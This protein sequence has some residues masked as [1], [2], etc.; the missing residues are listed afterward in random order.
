MKSVSEL[1]STLTPDNLVETL[2]RMDEA[3]GDNAA[4][5]EQLKAVCRSFITTTLGTLPAKSIDEDLLCETYKYLDLSK[6]TDFQRRRLREIARRRVF[7]QHATPPLRSCKSAHQLCVW[8]AV[9]CVFEERSLFERTV[10]FCTYLEAAAL[11]TEKVTSGRQSAPKALALA[12]Q[13]L[14]RRF[15]EACHIVQHAQAA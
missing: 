14:H 5:R 4:E 1:P 3:I 12:R 11:H 2:T 6:A 9:I 15:V 7:E 13:N 10:Q 8:Y